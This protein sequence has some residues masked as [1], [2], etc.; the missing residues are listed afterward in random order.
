MIKIIEPVMID[1]VR[2]LYGNNLNN[3]EIAEKLNYE[4]AMDYTEKDV[5]IYFE[6]TIEEEVEDLRMIYDNIS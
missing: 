5:Q 3:K 6:P 4:F 1:L 2:T